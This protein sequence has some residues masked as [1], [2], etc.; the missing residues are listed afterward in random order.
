[1]KSDILRAPFPAFG[2]KSRAANL[3]WA[4]LGEVRNYVEPFCNSC[5]VLLGRPQPFDGCET[6][7]DMDGFIANFWRALQADPDAVAHHCDWPVNELDLHARHQWLV[8][9]GVEHVARLRTEPDYF[10]AKIAGWWCWGCCQ[11]IGSGWCHH[12]EW[13]Q[14]PHLG[15]AGRGVH[16]PSQQLPHLGDAGRGDS[17]PEPETPE[18]YQYLNLL[19]ERFRRVRVCCGDWSRV[20]GPTPTVKQ[21]LTGVFLD[22]PYADTAERDSDLYAVDSLSVAHDVRE[23][24]LANGDDPRLRICLAGYE[25]EHQMPESWEVVEWKA[26]GGYGSQR[27]SGDNENAKK[28]RLWFSPHCLKPNANKLRQRELLEVC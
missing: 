11:W 3:V 19:A 14:L 18:I 8:N 22:P 16:R 27:L 12:P 26:K 20:C 10:D 13:E 5:A 2:G 4:R 15:N 23:W 28:E 9:V 6:V 21:G 1:M 24:A 7:N 25:G 17:S